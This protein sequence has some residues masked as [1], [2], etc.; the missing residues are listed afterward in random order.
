MEI[1]QN[2]IIAGLILIFIVLVI[3]VV[4]ISFIYD[5]TSVLTKV[6]FTQQQLQNTSVGVGS[7]SI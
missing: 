5:K 1:N 4:Y 2:F 3:L 7:T 6:S